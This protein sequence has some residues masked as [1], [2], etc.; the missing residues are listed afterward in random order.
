MARSSSKL[1]PL[2]RRVR[3]AARV[4]VVRQ[5]R[6]LTI[7][8]ADADG[9]FY[10]LPGGGQQNGESL[11]EA[12]RRETFEETGLAV[13]VGGLLYV[14]DYIGALHGIEGHEGFHQVEVVFAA[15]L[16]RE[17]AEPA[18]AHHPDPRQTGTAW[19][20]LR[21]LPDARF[22]PQALRHCFADGAC[23]PPNTYLGSVN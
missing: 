1:A 5:A 21:T 3:V 19:L 20:D 4:V 17:D 2:G 8:M 10:L 23:R 11:L 16:A 7:A 15:E 18:Q 6:L 9:P 14:R 22:Y 12:A 13:D